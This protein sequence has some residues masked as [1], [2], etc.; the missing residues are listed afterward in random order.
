[1]TEL[2]FSER[3]AQLAR[4]HPEAPAVTIVDA[5]GST[6][7]QV[8]WRTLVDR[9]DD[10]ARVLYRCG[11]RPNDFV[12]VA[13]ANN[14]AFFVACLASWRLGAI[15]Q[16]VSSHLPAAELDAIV[17]L[18]DS[19]AVIGVEKDRYPDRTCL[20]SADL[21]AVGFGENIELGSHISAAW[22][23]PTSGGS[24][25]RPKLIVSADPA[26][27]DDAEPGFPEMLRMVPGTATLIPG[28]MYHNGPFVWAFQ[29]L[30]HDG[31]AVVLERF[32]AEAT[33]DA[34]SRFQVSTVYLVP[35]MMSR[36][37]KLPDTVRARYDLS[38]VETFW[39]L[40]A[41]CPAW[42]KD[43]WIDWLGAS[44]VWELYGGTEGQCATVIDGEQWRAHRG[45]VGRPIMGELAIFDD[46]KRPVAT[47][48][49]GEVY[50]RPDRGRTT[51]RYIGAEARRAVGGW[52]SLGDMGWL[53]GEGYL[54]LTDRRTDMILSGGANIYPAEV[55]AALETHP[56]V[57]SCAVVG[58]PDDDLGQR[59]HAVV[60]APGAREDELL[61]HLMTVL[62][63][64][65]VPRS[66]EFVD[67]PVRDDA[68]KVRRSSL[69]AKRGGSA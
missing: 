12:T 28:P 64:Y 23:A 62:V 57:S 14:V 48:T 45:S 54:Y 56:L 43:A 25:G 37:W 27:Y 41:P 30:L 10:I 29:Q 51:Y 20:S 15:P 5:I 68:G 19:S 66:I 26:I 4:R 7:E 69:V 67:T 39:H 50:M 52:E 40:A 21:L 58:L 22:K 3:F 24:T 44:R 32:D 11:V 1:M 16:P 9:A 65:K 63:R 42:L 33:L 35:T 34:I 31:H 8:S 38:S 60:Y 61:E 47:G 13:L 36:I 18:A 17:T 6:R 46:A 49:I 53:D 59:V 2:S 55:E